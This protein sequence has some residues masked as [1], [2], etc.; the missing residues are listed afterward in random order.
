MRAT[1]DTPAVRAVIGR[2]DVVTTRG[3]DGTWTAQAQ[4][5]WGSPAATGE[6]ETEAM[7]Q[8]LC[9]CIMKTTIAIE[10]R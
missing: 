6:T 10:E 4:G 2:W 3:E 9:E 1:M 7:L 8:L 5:L